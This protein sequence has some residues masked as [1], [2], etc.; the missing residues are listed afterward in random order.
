MRLMHW[1]SGLI[2]LFNLGLGFSLANT[3]LFDGSNTYDVP[4]HKSFGVLVFLLV[5]MRLLIRFGSEL[6]RSA[7]HVNKLE[8]IAEKFTHFALYLFLISIPLIGYSMSNF[9]GRVVSFFGLFNL[10]IIFSQNKELAKQF[11]EIHE[12][13]AYIALGFIGLHILAT[14]KHYI[15]NKENLLKKM[16]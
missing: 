11:Y 12:L 7:N 16:I 9:S 6:P 14:V 3:K 5:I 8:K 2:F 15:F 10:P 13:S 4:L 1:T